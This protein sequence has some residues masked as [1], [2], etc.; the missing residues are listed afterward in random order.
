M[1]QIKDRLH[2]IHDKYTP[3]TNNVISNIKTIDYNSLK[4]SLTKLP[5]LGD[6]WEPYFDV[7]IANVSKQ[8]P[9]DFW[10]LAEDLPK[11]QGEIVGTGFVANNNNENIKRLLAVEGHADA[12][13]RFMN[14]RRTIA[15]GKVAANSFMVVY[16]FV[17]AMKIAAQAI[18]YEFK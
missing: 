18:D 11:Y 7:I 17:L 4:D 12:K 1:Q 15:S 3:L 9:N 2:L 14:I 5:T 8:R 16:P 13:N 6:E 10:K